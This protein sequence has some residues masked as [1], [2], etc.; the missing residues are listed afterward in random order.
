MLVHDI[1]IDHLFLNL[2]HCSSLYMLKLLD[3]HQIQQSQDRKCSVA[4]KAHFSHFPKALHFQKPA[5]RI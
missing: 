5:G 3:L 2:W 4:E 1:L